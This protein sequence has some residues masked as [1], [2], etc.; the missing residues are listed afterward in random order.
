MIT[1]QTKTPPST[2]NTSYNRT[3]TDANKKP[4]IL[5][6]KNVIKKITEEGVCSN[7][8]QKDS[9]IYPGSSF[10]LCIPCDKKQLY[11]KEELEERLIS[12]G[13]CP[14]CERKDSILYSSSL[15]R[16]CIE[17]DTAINLK[18]TTQDSKK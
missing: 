13:I 8:S 18:I 14:Q 1:K 9:M 11:T 4:I 5:A 12:L 7:C 2:T 6:S 15:F 17:C 16:T 10:S 3:P